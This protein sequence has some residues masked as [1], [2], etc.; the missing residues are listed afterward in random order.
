MR[1]MNNKYNKYKHNRN[2]KR[3]RYQKYLVDTSVIAQKKLIRIFRKL[4]G[5]VLIPNAVVAELENLANKG[6]DAG[7]I[8]LE[9]IARLHKLK[10]RIK[11]KFIGLRPACYQ[12]KLARSGEIDALIRELAYEFHATLITAD[13][14]QSK[15]A[16]AYGIPVKFI[17]TRLKPKPK[18]FLFFKKFKKSKK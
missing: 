17:K 15:S 18:K 14:V 11:I 3:A 10:P 5:E 13:V 8:G 12:I 7:F 6:D 1:K 9:E 4:D 2:K 16:M